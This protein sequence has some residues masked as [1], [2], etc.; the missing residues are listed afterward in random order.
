MLAYS[1]FT[2]ALLTYLWLPSQENN[3]DTT[4]GECTREA[5]MN[6]NGTHTFR[7]K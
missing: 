1:T 7:G 4:I 6:E 5:S 3:S 2:I